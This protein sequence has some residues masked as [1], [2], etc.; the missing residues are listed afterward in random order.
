MH[1]I[2]TTIARPRS[3]NNDH[4]K[5]L[6]EAATQRERRSAMEKIGD[7]SNR[8]ESISTTDGFDTST[9]SSLTHGDQNAVQ[10]KRFNDLELFQPQYFSTLSREIRQQLS[11]WKT[12]D[13]DLVG[14]RSLNT[15]YSD[16]SDKEAL[17]FRSD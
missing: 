1:S 3:V 15:L 2:E 7:D 6:R 13:F 5:R 8:P 12:W 4:I 14:C 11:L 10:Q 17:S 16:P 9:L